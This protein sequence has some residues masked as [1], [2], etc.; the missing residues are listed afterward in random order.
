MKVRK[1][2]ALAVGAA[3][4]GATMGYANAQL[5]VPKDFFVKDGA[6]NVKIVVG[7]NAAAMDVASAADIAVAL[8]SLLFTAEEVSADVASVTVKKDYTTDP[9]DILL[10]SALYGDYGENTKDWKY[11]D[12]PQDAW[13]NAASGEYEY[14]FDLTSFDPSDGFD[15]TDYFLNA[16]DEYEVTIEDVESITPGAKA[17]AFDKNVVLN[18]G[19]EYKLIDYTITIGE[20]DV[21]GYKDPDRD[22]PPKSAKVKIP[23][24]EMTVDIDFTIEAGK[25]TKHDSTYGYETESYTKDDHVSSSYTTTTLKGGLEKGDSFTLFGKTYYIIDVNGNASTP[26]FAFGTDHGTK[27]FHVGDTMEFNGYKVT[28]MDISINENR[29]LV[30]VV[31]PDGDEQLVIL[32]SSE[33][34]KDVFDDGGIILTLKNTFVGIDGN[35]IATINVVTNREE[36]DTGSKDFVDGY[37]VTLKFNADGDKLTGMTLTNEEELKGSEIELFD[38]YSVEYVFKDYS[39]EYEDEDYYT[40]EAYVAIDPIHTDWEEI[41]TVKP[42]ETFDDPDTGDSYMVEAEGSSYTKITPVPPAE[43]ITLL[44]SEVD[45]NNVTSNLILVGGPVANS[46]TAYL[47]DQGLSTV[48]WTASEGDLE[49]IENAFGDYDVLIVAGKARE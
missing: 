21:Y 3:M 24:G 9:D 10:Y 13:Y 39:T 27:W 26:Y 2:A 29:A 6:P 40:A 16:T 31:S 12:L 30:K 23:K 41:A 49:Y 11:S 35:L 25:K 28:A 48:D 15:V 37:E 34:E 44:D 47:V 43:P 36:V 46:V 20:L 8:G 4:I 1:I 17:T 32:D 19:E 7:S 42:G 5:N 38:T 33:P 18:A 14:D 45:V 22:V